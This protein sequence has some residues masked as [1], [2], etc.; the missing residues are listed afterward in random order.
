M[1]VSTFEVALPSQSTTNLQDLPRIAYEL[2]IT[3]LDTRPIEFHVDATL[4]HPRT[5]FSPTHPLIGWRL[6]AIGSPRGTW[7]VHIPQHVTTVFRLDAEQLSPE[8]T[9]DGRRGLDG[10]P[11]RGYVELRVPP[12]RVNNRIGAQSDAPVPVLLAAHRIQYRGYQLERVYFDEN[13][14]A[15]AREGQRIWLGDDWSTAAIELASGAAHNLI[16]PE[17]YFTRGVGD[18]LE[19]DQTAELRAEDCGAIYLSESERPQALV[20]LLLSLDLRP[21]ELERLNEYLASQGSEFRVR[22]DE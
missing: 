14:L 4:T 5:A 2:S 6:T 19:S 13:P 22:E 9:Q 20:D 18:L 21:G 10:S 3:N 7:R 16:E 15:R 1:L 17:S 8:G 11:R 12:G